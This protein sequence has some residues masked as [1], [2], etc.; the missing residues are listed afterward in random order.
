MGGSLVFD[1]PLLGLVPLFKRSPLDHSAFGSR[2]GNSSSGAGYRTV[3]N[4]VFGRPVTGRS[5]L[6]GPALSASASGLGC[7]AAGSLVLGRSE[8]GRSLPG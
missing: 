7:R 6:G 5:T 4:L 1:G 3:G 8:A 2:L